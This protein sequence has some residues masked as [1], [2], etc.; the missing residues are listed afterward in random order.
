[1]TLQ[2]LVLGH[3]LGIFNSY[4]RRL[5]C[6]RVKVVLLVKSVLRR[7]HLVEVPSREG[8]IDGLIF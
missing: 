6:L 2:T 7:L 4:A 1:M 5:R 3:E 8:A